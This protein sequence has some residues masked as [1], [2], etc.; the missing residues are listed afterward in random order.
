MGA[1]QLSY[2]SQKLDQ[3]CQDGDPFAVRQA[4]EELENHI[5]TFMN[6]AK[7]ILSGYTGQHER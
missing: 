3:K 7:T 2:L 6:E 5:N 4:L 1:M